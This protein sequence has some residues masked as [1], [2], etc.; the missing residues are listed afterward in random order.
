MADEN[1]LLAGMAGAI[2]AVVAAMKLHADNAGVLEHAC[3]AMRS[4]CF[5]T[6]VFGIECVFL[7]L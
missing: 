4:I 5:N 1:Q 7:L 2:D 3:G 6:G